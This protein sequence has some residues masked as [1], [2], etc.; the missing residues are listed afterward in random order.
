MSGYSS[1]GGLSISSASDHI[2]PG[3]HGNSLFSW[4][5]KETSKLASTDS[6]E[7]ANKPWYMEDQDLEAE[8]DTDVAL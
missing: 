5:D 4:D 1:D 3:N 8:S 7:C 6:T 2:S